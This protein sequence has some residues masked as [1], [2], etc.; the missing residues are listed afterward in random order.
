LA[1]PNAVNTMAVVLVKL[2]PAI[3]VLTALLAAHPGQAA[4]PAW[5]APAV[6]PANLVLVEVAV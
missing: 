1:R 6:A 5:D 4:D 2:V 3:I